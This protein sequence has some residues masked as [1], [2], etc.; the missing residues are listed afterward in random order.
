MEEHEEDCEKLLYDLEVEGEDKSYTTEIGT[1]HNGGGK[2][3]GAF[4]MYM[5]PWHADIVAFLHAKKNTGPEEERARDLFYGLWIPDLFMKRVQKNG[6]WSLMCPMEC[7]GLT[8]AHGDAFDRLY[9]EY[10]AKGMYRKQMAARELFTEMVKSQI[11]T[12]TPYFLYKD[13]CNRKSN[14]KHLGTIKSSNLCVS[15]ETMLL[16]RNGYVPMEK[17]V[18]E[19]VEAWNGETFERVVPL[20]TKGDVDPGD[21]LYITTTSG[22][23]L[24]CTLDHLFL[25]GENEKRVK[26]VDLKPGMEVRAWKVPSFEL[27]SSNGREEILRVFS[28]V[29]RHGVYMNEP[30][31]GYYFLCSWD[32]ESLRQLQM[33]LEIGSV[34]SKIENISTAGDLKQRW[35]LEIPREEWVKLASVG[36]SLSSLTTTGSS[37]EVTGKM[38]RVDRVDKISGRIKTKPSY[39]LREPMKHTVVFQG[40]L[41]GQCTEIIEYSDASQYAVCNLASISLPS[42]LKF[43]KGVTVPDKIYVRGPMEADMLDVQWVVGRIKEMKGKENK[44]EVVEKNDVPR[45]MVRFVRSESGTGKEEERTVIQ[46]FNE[47]VCPV[48]DLKELYRITKE[49]TYNLNQVIDKNRYPTSETRVSNLTHRPIGIGVQGLADVF[50]ALKISFDS[51]Q[52]RQL[53]QQIFETI[54]HAALAASC[55]CAISNGG[56]YESY[57]GSPL[58]D[59]KFHWEL[60]APEKPYFPM[61]HDWESLRKRVLEHGILNS[62]M[63]A[64]MPTASTSQILGNNE[65]FEPYTSNFY[66]R[67]TSAGEFLIY[68][69]EL[70]RDLC[71]LRMWTPEVR[72]KLLW[73]RGSVR[74]IEGIPEW[75]M[76]VYKT[77]WELPQKSIIDQ[78][79]DRHFFVDQ[80]QSMNLF[81]A[82]PNLDTL[83]KMHFYGFSKGLKTGSYYIR[84]R[85]PLSTPHFALEASVV[86][87]GISTTATGAVAACPYRRKNK[88]SPKQEEEEEE[89][90]SCSA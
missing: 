13:A 20:E 56:P 23:R 86:S 10:E 70:H 76:E 17:C 12:G 74:G 81:L 25:I 42:C 7:P 34:T 3:N 24:E 53:N 66:T 88:D 85:P 75:M 90:L 1:V 57:E 29:L 26:A 8:D 51:L 4:A 79:V 2:R 35:R 49:L 72:N 31:K 9:E 14:Q 37:L 77:V 45:G 19:T 5:E 44:I 78:A 41:T 67:R 55:D 43:P 50:C 16:T 64:P 52:A 83:M 63:I 68:N 89:C 33:T 54:Y 47:F 58:S 18:G 80:S 62:L 22:K 30:T 6:M 39:C 32:E 48:M 38:D 69:R 40:M 36:S 27:F 61:I 71:A 65:C 46:F 21:W 15:G 60:C 82:E 11:E 28:Y 73:N 59:G 84:T 87:T